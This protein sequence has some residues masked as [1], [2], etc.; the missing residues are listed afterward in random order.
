MCGVLPLVE[1]KSPLFGHALISTPFCVYGGPCAETPEMEAELT[2]RAIKLATG[3]QVDYLEFRETT[4]QNRDW[5]GKDFYYRFY[6]EIGSDNDANLKAVP[7]KQRAMIRKGMQN[8]LVS[9][10]ENDIDNFYRIYA[11]SV[12]DL[13][14]PVYPKRYFHALKSEFGQQC[15][16][17]TVSKDAKPVASVFSLYFKNTVMPYYGGGLSTARDLKAYD[18]MYWE[19]MRRSAEQ[20]LTGFDYGRSIAGT[21]SF[22]FKKNWG[23]QPQPLFYRQYLVN[24]KQTPDINPNNA[25]YRTMIA[26]WKKLPLPIANSIGPH[27]AKYLG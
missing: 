26:L 12:R 1:V 21:G 20:G 11:T 9:E 16:I 25:K 8:D 14:T 4:D 17:L 13:G 24:A 22:S 5:S 19:L 27:V 23:F 15:R 10:F 2:E 18:F 7:R 6:K 3:L